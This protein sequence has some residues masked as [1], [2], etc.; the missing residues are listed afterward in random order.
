M[1]IYEYGCTACGDRFEI[2]QR[3]SDDPL[4]KCTKCGGELKKL[5]SNTSF[6]L[7]GAGWYADG[8]ASPGAKSESKPAKGGNGSSDKAAKAEAP[9]KSEKK[10]S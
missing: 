8:Y 9:K 2:M 5:I 10:S 4:V 7:K 3:F 6:V 1:P